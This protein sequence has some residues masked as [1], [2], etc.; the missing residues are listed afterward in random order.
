MLFLKEAD[1][2]RAEY[3][4]HLVWTRLERAFSRLSKVNKDEAK[5]KILFEFDPNFY[6][7]TIE[8][9]IDFE[10]YEVS[11]LCSGKLVDKVTSKTK[12]EKSGKL[13]AEKILYTMLG[14][15]I[16]RRIAPK[17]I[18]AL[19]Y[20]LDYSYLA[21]LGAVLEDLQNSMK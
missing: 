6:P 7:G 1:E 18:L 14:D 19:G 9:R 16:K 3:D 17:D 10:R 13:L 15:C 5:N 2:K 21:E 20:N 12:D 4:K 8:A 11:I